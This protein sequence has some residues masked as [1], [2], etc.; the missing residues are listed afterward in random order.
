MRLVLAIAITVVTAFPGAVLAGARYRC[1]ISGQVM[2]HACCRSRARR[3]AGPP[4]V[5]DQ[6]RAAS[7]CELIPA[8]L[9]PAQAPG[10]EAVPAIDASAEYLA[11]ATPLLL[12]PTLLA[13][14]PPD[15]RHRARPISATSS[16]LDRAAARAAGV[17]IQHCSLQL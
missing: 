9:C 2:G 5:H 4:P 10:E 13:P 3:S 15:A 8:G 7:C 14:P 17:C 12:S 16:R 6:V 11:A 1:H